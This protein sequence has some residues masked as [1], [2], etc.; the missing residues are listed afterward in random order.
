MT[1]AHVEVE[2]SLKNVAEEYKH[3]V[4]PLLWQHNTNLKQKALWG[5]I[6]GNKKIM[7]YRIIEN[8]KGKHLQEIK[9]IL[10]ASDEIVIVSPFITEEAIIAL[11]EAMESVKSITV[12]TTMKQQDYDQLNKIPVLHKLFSI[13]ETNAV[14]LFVKI[15]NKLHGKIYAG[16]KDGV[17]TGAIITSA[18]LTSNG[19]EY[20]HE[21]GINISDS[22]VIEGICDQILSETEKT[23]YKDDLLDMEAWV[24]AHPVTKAPRPKL[25]KNLLDFVQPKIIMSKG[26]TYWLKPYG[27]KNQYVPAYM[28]FDQE[29]IDI[30]LAKGVGSIK[31]GDVLL[32]YAVGSRQIISIFEATG[33]CG[34]KTVFVNKRDKRWPYYVTCKNLTPKFGA[35]WS[36]ANVTLDTLISSYLRLY[37]TK[38]IR[39]GSQ[40]L[41]VMQWG[42]DRL[43]L[44]K[45]FGYFVTREVMKRLQHD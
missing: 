23:I 26:I 40:N 11:E 41:A 33:K 14:N 42:R 6:V 43:R 4:H 19:M 28:K 9:D 44:D 12:V 39:P 27:T 16:K 22:K 36:D 5:C 3:I 24:K 34:I 31:K 35:Q 17:Y 13:A 25:Q 2:K 29:E 8:T 10:K 21:W 30:T 32:V 45:D 1:R 38:D 15:D 7:D 20:N 37:P 18:N